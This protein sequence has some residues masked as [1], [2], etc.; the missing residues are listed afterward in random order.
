MDVDISTAGDASHAPVQSPPQSQSQ[1][2]SRVNTSPTSAANAAA[3]AAG[4]TSF[5]RYTARLTRSPF[6]V[7]DADGAVSSQA[8][9]VQS[10]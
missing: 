5:R 8:A 2:D 3:L 10:V 6:S 4:Q 9:S 7:V 1:S